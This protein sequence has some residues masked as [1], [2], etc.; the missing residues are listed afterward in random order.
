M[1]GSDRVEALLAELVAIPSVN[2]EGRTDGPAHLWGEARVAE[3]VARYFEDLDVEVTG[4]PVL[5]GRENVVVIARGEGTGGGLLCLEAHMDTVGVEGM[6]RP[7]EPVLAAGRIHGRGSCDTKASLAAMMIALRRVVETGRVPGSGVVLVGAVDEEHGHAGVRALVG[8][9]LRLAAAVVGE[10]TRLEVVAAHKGQAYLLA[11]ARG[12]AAHTST[13]ERGTNAI[14]LMGDALRSIEAGAPAAFAARGHGLTGPSVVTVSMIRGGRSEHIV[15]DE[16]EATLDL[17][18]APG[19]EEAEALGALQRLA[20][21]GLGADRAGAVA[22]EA[23]YHRA[24]ALDTP[25]DHP[26]VRGLAAAVAEAG[27]EARV[28]GAPYN[29]DASVLAAASVPAVVFGPGDIAQAHAAEEHVDLAE[30]VAAATILERFIA[31]W[32]LE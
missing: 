13:P 8:S 24:S 20:D 6:A 3:H 7:F 26:V 22:I 1:A 32:R 16:C 14:L 23:P 17:R 12:R 10:P 19:H 29:T 28:A 2:P 27:R 9:G 25:V 11:R 18:L 4:Q 5:P 31:A 15:P 21:E 30:V